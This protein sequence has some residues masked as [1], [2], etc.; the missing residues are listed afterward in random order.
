MS[1]SKKTWLQGYGPIQHSEE[2]HQAIAQMAQHLVETGAQPNLDAVYEKLIAL[3]RLTAAAMWVA[4]QPPH[5]ETTH[6]FAAID[7]HTKAPCPS[8]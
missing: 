1:Q 4:S 5:A 3:D 8:H 2:T 6:A 7:I